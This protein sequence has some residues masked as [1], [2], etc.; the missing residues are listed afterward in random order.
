[1]VSDEATIGRRHASIEYRDHAYWVTDQN[2][3]NGTYV[4]KR[5]IDGGTQL[6]HGDRLRFHR[7]EFEF[8]MLD[9]F[10]TDRTM[11]SETMF[12][13][14]A[15]TTADDEDE[16]QNDVTVQRDRADTTERPSTP[17]PD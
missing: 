5:R 7:H 14:L 10:E 1:M 2:S 15:A 17:K 8:L 13:N 3:L 9:M 6:K 16:D 4:N 11:V 12:A